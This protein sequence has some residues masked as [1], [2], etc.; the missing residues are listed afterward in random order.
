MSK[1]EIK[2]PS[3]VWNDRQQLPWLISLSTPHFW[4]VVL[5]YDCWMLCLRTRIPRQGGRGKIL[6]IVLPWYEFWCNKHR[7]Q[8]ASWLIFSALKTNDLP[9]GAPGPETQ[10]R[11]PPAG[12]TIRAQLSFPAISLYGIACSGAIGS[13]AACTGNSDQCLR[14]QTAK[15]NSS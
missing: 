15:P 6:T 8:Q 13:S 12:V 7:G 14:S 10:P 5:I 11:W 9:K 3:I 1:W 2:S 4:C